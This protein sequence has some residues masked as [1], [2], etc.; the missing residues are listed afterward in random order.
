MEYFVLGPVEVR[1]AAHEP[2]ALG[3][4]LQVHLLAL[5]LTNPGTVFST[6]Q[7]IE[8]LWPVQPPKSAASN[9]RTYVWSLRRILG[10]PGTAGSRVVGGTRGYRLLVDN[11]IVDTALFDR[12][13]HEGYAKLHGNDGAGA[14]EAFENALA[15]WRGVPFQDLPVNGTLLSSRTRLEDRRLTLVEEIADLYL[16]ADRH[17]EIIDRLRDHIAVDPLRERPWGQLMTALYHAGRKAEALAA[18]R[19]LHKRLSGDIGV[20]PTAEIQALHRRILH[21]DLPRTVRVHGPTTI[22]T[23]GM[24]ANDVSP[25]AERQDATPHPQQLPPDVPGFVGREPELDAL[26]RLLYSAMRMAVICGMPG[27]G[28]TAL[29]VHWAHRVSHAFPD[30]QLYV[31]LRGHGPGSPMPPL[32][33]LTHLLES[34][35]MS[36]HRVPPDQHRAT[37]LFRSAVANKRVLLLLD[38]AISADQVRPLLPGSPTTC[39]IVTS[40]ERLA[41]LVAREGVQQIDLPA[42]SQDHAMT[43]LA[44]LLDPARVAAEEPSAQE[45]ARLC[46]TLPLALRIA[47][48]TINRQSKSPIA[49]LVER[50]YASSRLTTLKIHDD[51]QSAIDAAFDSS[52]AVLDPHLQQVFR[53]LYL[54]PV[55]DFTANAVAALM[56]LPAA[57][58]QD[59]LRRIEDAHL[60]E[61]LGDDR[62]TMHDLVREY[63][64]RL[65][66]LDS[67][68]ERVAA[69][70]RVQ[71]WYLRKT[72]A[73][74]RALYPQLVR[75]PVTIGENDQIDGPAAVQ[76]LAAEHRNLVMVATDA[77]GTASPEVTWLLSSTLRG[78]FMSCRDTTAW[79]NVA[80]EALTAATAHANVQAQAAAHHSLGLA[81]NCIGDFGSAI[82]HCTRATELAAQIGWRELRASALLAL[83]VC[84]SYRGQT[85]QAIAHLTLSLRLNRSLGNVSSTAIA[86]NNLGTIDILRGRLAGAEAR[87]NESLRLHRQAATRRGAASALINLGV[88][89]RHRGDLIRARAGLAEAGEIYRQLSDVEG[90]AKAVRELAMVELLSKRTA[91]ALV[92]ARAA[93]AAVRPIGDLH[94]EALAL[95]TLGTI[96]ARLGN[97]R[98]AMSY[99]QRSLRLGQRADSRQATVAAL[100]SL[101][102]LYHRQGHHD[103]AYKHAEQAVPLAQQA[104][105]VPYQQQALHI[106]AGVSPFTI[107]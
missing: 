54:L 3:P 61:A 70:A 6:D 23:E 74:A 65:S 28:K 55:R 100:V 51:P 45:L 18:Y 5:L 49:D 39:V 92:H 104:E 101:A 105:Y 20:E 15:L 36:P 53:A 86:L 14:L 7:I 96:R 60:A 42:L 76:W 66:A 72:E 30:G 12:M 31:D 38:N 22:R 93:L 102:E 59:A 47:A 16:Q 27:L 87:L 24:P 107:D 29:T 17:S 84:H 34:L 46:G 91:E 73:A 79:L 90:E 97:D 52:Y 58:V 94:A 81:Y 37:G 75:L 13:S 56:A 89:A 26:D 103:L 68:E 50:L 99:Y 71:G 88:V 25:V 9:I 1:S 82:D 41:G 21:G 48:A 19:Q 57:D 11:D 83:G 77:A 64:G 43:L 8:E 4:P 44:R 10:R 35:G 40:R 63:A 78:Q 33:A 95:H 62:Y 2:V 98:L 32:E 80:R 67:P 69:V 106:L 85:T